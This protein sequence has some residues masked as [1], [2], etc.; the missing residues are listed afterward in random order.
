MANLITLNSVS[1]VLD[2]ETGYTYPIKEDN[3]VVL[4]D[5]VSLADCC[6]EWIDSLS[7]E[8][9]RLC[10]VVFEDTGALWS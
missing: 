6:D 5:A 9:L 4:S 10:C 3:T 8:D 7:D 1:C 2:P